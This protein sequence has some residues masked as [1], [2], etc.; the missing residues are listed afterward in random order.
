MH[1]KRKSE[2]PSPE[3]SEITLK[4]NNAKRDFE[5]SVFAHSFGEQNGKSQIEEEGAS[6]QYQNGG[7]ES[8][9]KVAGAWIN[10]NDWQHLEEKLARN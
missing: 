6:L 10:G 7:G 2:T 9:L 4:L 1:E 8:K 5:V 3:H